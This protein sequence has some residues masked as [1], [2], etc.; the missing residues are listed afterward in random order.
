MAPVYLLGIGLLWSPF[1]AVICDQ[2]AYRRRLVE[3]NYLKAGAI[4]SALLF[5]PWVYLIVRMII[6]SPVPRV[7]V[8]IGRTLIAIGYIL[9]YLY[10]FVLITFFGEMFIV[11]ISYSDSYWE[12]HGRGVWTQIV[13]TGSATV[14][15]SLHCLVSVMR[16]LRIRVRPSSVE[17]GDVEKSQEHPII[18]DNRFIKPVFHILLW[19]IASVILLVV[20]IGAGCC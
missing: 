11:S 7:A 4:H 3:G 8:V 10:W 2:I 1:A 14:G 9:L 19:V 17:W 5:L 20:L 13:I 15:M 6:P 16:L 18:P 12:Y